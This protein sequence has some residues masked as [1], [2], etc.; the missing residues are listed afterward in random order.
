MPDHAAAVEP[1]LKAADEALYAAKSAGRNRV[2]AAGAPP[3]P[4][5]DDAETHQPA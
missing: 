1:L 4:H 5:D 3:D 2:M